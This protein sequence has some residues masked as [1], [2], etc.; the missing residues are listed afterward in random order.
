[1]NRPST[2][3]VP[4]SYAREGY[5]VLHKTELKTHTDAL[6]A[7]QAE[8]INDNYDIEIYVGVHGRALKDG[9]KSGL[10]LIA[11]PT[12]EE[13]DEV[14]AVVG[15]MHPG[16]TLFIEGYGFARQPSEPVRLSELLPDVAE[17]ESHDAALRAFGE[18]ALSMVAE[19]ERYSRAQLEQQ[20]NEYAIGAWQYAYELA[21]LKGVQTIFADHDAFEHKSFRALNK[22][23]EPQELLTSS[24][25]DDQGLLERLDAQ[26]ERT[27][28]N[29][30][31]DWALDHL[32][33][34]DAA[35]P[36]DRKSKLV[37][38]FGAAHKEGLRQAFADIGLDA[39][40]TAMKRTSNQ[41]RASE[42]AR[43]MTRNTTA[44]L[45]PA[46]SKAIHARRSEVPTGSA[47]FGKL[48]TFRS[49]VRKFQVPSRN[50]GFGRRSDKSE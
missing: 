7:D 9:P 43:R 44:D 40:V 18:L 48:K 8:R 27:A 29:M 22:G 3:L 4:R 10:D 25:E 30:I 32:P 35:L 19:L 5:N 33:A 15:S 12:Q 50:K 26:R 41:E 23:R 28:R 11:L 2:E 24:T 31:K 21:E 16:D 6:T 13:Y 42:Q 20:R 37:L 17:Q 1:M 49:G 39:N 38:L 45:M 14:A 36:S 46:I 34:D 47:G